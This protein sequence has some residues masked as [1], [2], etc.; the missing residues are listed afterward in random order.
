MTK[1][2]LKEIEE[3]F[4]IVGFNLF[5]VKIENFSLNANNRF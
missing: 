4:C 2:L 3:S 1:Y 5:E